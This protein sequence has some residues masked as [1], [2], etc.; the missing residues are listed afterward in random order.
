MGANVAYCR[1][2]SRGQTLATQRAAIEQAAKARGEQID[3]WFEDKATGTKLAR[4]GLAEL[5][6]LVRGGGA[7]RCYVFRLDRL[8]RSG[9]RDAVLLVDE[10][11]RCGCELVTIADGFSLD[12]PAS[13]MVVAMI[14]WLAKMERDAINERI[15]AARDRIEAEGGRWGRARKMGPSEVAKAWQLKGCGLS[16]RKISQHLRVPRSTVCDALRPERR[17]GISKCP[18]S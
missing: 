17:P 10:F 14:A 4:P 9:V 6:S 11:R 16:I 1:V 12:G 15:S 5:R 3:V 18:S 8:L 2:S 7:S 13:E